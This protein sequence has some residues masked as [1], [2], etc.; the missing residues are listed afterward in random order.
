MH[1]HGPEGL[2]YVTNSGRTLYPATVQWRCTAVSL[3]S[4]RSPFTG[5]FGPCLATAS[6][7]PGFAEATQRP[8]HPAAPISLYPF[9]LVAPTCH[10]FR[11]SG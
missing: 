9:H 3:C 1:V 6:A 11:F 10:T 7:S 8:S 2:L 5:A 4:D